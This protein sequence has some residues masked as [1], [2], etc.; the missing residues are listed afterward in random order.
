MIGGAFSLETRIQNTVDLFLTPRL[1]LRAQRTRRRPRPASPRF[2]LRKAQGRPGAKA[3]F[4]E[5]TFGQHLPFSP[6]C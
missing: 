2:F 1:M 5:R 3:S 6:P 4:D